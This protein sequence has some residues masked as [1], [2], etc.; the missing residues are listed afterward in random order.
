VEL[1]LN[2]KEMLMNSEV[3]KINE[4][5]DSLD[6]VRGMEFRYKQALAEKDRL[7]DLFNKAVSELMSVSISLDEARDNYDKISRC[8]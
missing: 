4:L 3:V 1:N 2:L 7:H 8:Q 5:E 6:E